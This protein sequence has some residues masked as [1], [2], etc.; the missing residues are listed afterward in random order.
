MV[1]FSHLNMTIGK[2]IALAIWRFVSEVM[3]LLFNMLSRFVIAF[4]PRSKNLLISWLW[5]FWS[6]RKEKW[7]LLLLFSLLFAMMWWDWMPCSHFFEC[8]DSS[9]LFHSPLS[10][11]SRDSSSFSL[12]AYRVVICISEVDDISA[13]SLD[14]NL[15][16]TQP[17]ISH[18]VLWKEV[19]QGDN[20]QTC[21]TP[22]PIFNQSIVP[23]PILTVA[24]QSTYRFL[25]RQVRWS[26]IPISL[27]I[28]HSL[29]WSIQSKVWHTQWRIRWLS[30]ILLLFPW[31]NK[32][33]QFNLWFLCLF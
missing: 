4:I 22:F 18:D 26:G 13:C 5:W 12:S 6:P 32:S 3:S 29:L 23:C 11:S 14:S 8:W 9:Q 17:G 20:I 28:F 30:G 31:C 7:S 1:Q 2:A 16:V 33:W 19:K 27:R 15:W 10:P 24:S 25:K 21:H